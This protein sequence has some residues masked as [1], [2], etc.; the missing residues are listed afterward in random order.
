MTITSEVSG[1]SAEQ[2]ELWDRVDELWSLSRT[3]DQ[4]RIE[5]ALHPDYV[6]WDMNAPA[7][8][9]RIAAVLSVSADSPQL[10]QY[11]LQPQ[12]VQV[13]DHLVGVVHY[14][15]TATVLPSSAEAMEVAGKWMEVYLKHA[16]VWLMIA[17]GGRPD[18]QDVGAEEVFERVRARL[19][20]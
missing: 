17:V 9:D 8:H 14:S 4:K 3:R 16:G 19:K 5:A 20:R 13:Y 7:P 12:S 2:R 18:R 1:F 6:G 15:Y 10:T 11:T